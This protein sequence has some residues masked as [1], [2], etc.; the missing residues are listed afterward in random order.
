MENLTYSFTDLATDHFHQQRLCYAT[1][2]TFGKDW[3]GVLHAHGCTNSFMSRREKDGFVQMKQIF[4][5][6]KIN[7]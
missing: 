4:L 7:W 3:N 1:S 6:K 2:S 5:S